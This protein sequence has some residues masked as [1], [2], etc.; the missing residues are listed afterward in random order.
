MLLYCMSDLRYAE[1]DSGAAVLGMIIHVATMPDL[2]HGARKHLLAV[3]PELGLSIHFS[4]YRPVESK[5]H[6]FRG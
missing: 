6:H 3:E 4:M 2:E 1:A 5:V